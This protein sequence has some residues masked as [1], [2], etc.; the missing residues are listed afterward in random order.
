M[1]E[2]L[3]PEIN[4]KIAEKAELLSEK[5][6]LIETSNDKWTN[7]EEWR[8]IGREINRERFIRKYPKDEDE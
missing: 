8:R 1:K 7:R 4:K 5:F 6:K 2:Y 3:D